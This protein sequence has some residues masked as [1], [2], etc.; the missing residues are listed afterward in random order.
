MDDPIFPAARVILPYLG[1][2]VEPGTAAEL[3][4]RVSGLLDAAAQGQDTSAALRDALDGDEVTREFARKV[5]RDAPLFR[6]P[7]QQERGL[8][9]LQL[10]SQ[11]E[12]IAAPKYVC[13]QGDR[14]WF[15]LDSDYP[16][17]E[18]KIHHVRMVPAT[19]NPPGA[20][21]AGT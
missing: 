9:D 12:R 19:P 5:M 15:Q 8:R 14:V 16:I 4:T 11:P 7:G 6:P 18:C 13:P 17:P 21:D 2:L 10:A 20:R 3:R 1:Q